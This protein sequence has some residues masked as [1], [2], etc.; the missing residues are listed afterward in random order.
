MKIQ[1]NWSIYRNTLRASEQ[2]EIYSEEFMLL[3]KI[4]IPDISVD[5]HGSPMSTDRYLTNRNLLEQGLKKNRLMRYVYFSVFVVVNI[6]LII[7]ITSFFTI[8][9]LQEF[10]VGTVVTLIGLIIYME[11]F[12]RSKDIVKT[13][14]RDLSLLKE[15][16]FHSS[17]LVHVVEWMETDEAIAKYIKMR[18]QI[19][20]HNLTN[21]EYN[22]MSTFMKEGGSP[23]YTK[24]IEA[25]DKIYG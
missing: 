25:R 4:D 22:A 19:A 8:T 13:I 18:Q 17:K 5:I 20:K 9:H 1:L 7:G 24:Q 21:L 12:S 6:L 14:N 11:F 10:V 23:Q 16:P 15:I 3:P 2:L